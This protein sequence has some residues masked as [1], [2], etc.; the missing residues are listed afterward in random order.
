MGHGEDMRSDALR[1]YRRLRKAE[2][3][4][5]VRLEAFEKVQG[6]MGLDEELDEMRGRLAAM[7]VAI[8]ES[9]A[10]VMRLQEKRTNGNPQTR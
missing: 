2:R 4:L 6:V 7:Q 1:A 9:R 8:A 5:R 10:E 3:G